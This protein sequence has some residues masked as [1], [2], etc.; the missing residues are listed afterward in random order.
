MPPAREFSDCFFCRNEEVLRAEWIDM[1]KR[2]RR[3]EIY[4]FIIG[5]TA[6]AGGAAGVPLSRYLG[7]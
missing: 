1:M 5:F 6:F 4:L 3:I 2:L 7:L